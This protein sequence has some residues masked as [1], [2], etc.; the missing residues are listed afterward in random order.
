[1][2]DDRTVIQQILQGETGAYRILIKRYEARL[3]NLIRHLVPQADWED[4][5]Q[6]VFLAAYQNLHSFDA[7]QAS[8]ATWL[9]TIARHKCLNARKKRQ[10]L[11]VEQVP[12][13]VD[14]RAP[15]GPVLEQEWFQLLDKALSSLPF[16]QKSVFVLAE[17]QELTYEEISRI[18]GVSIGTIKSRLSRAKQK[19]RSVLPQQE[20]Y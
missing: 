6:E 16:E 19:L 20:P 17:L 12:E 3:G 8:F 9:L 2:K 13:E 4:L 5:A 10:P 11:F 1:M 14:H 7:G 18:E 15:E